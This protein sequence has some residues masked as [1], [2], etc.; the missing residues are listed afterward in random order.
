MF[1]NG[2]PYTDF[3]EMNLDWIIDSFNEF[4]SSFNELKQEWHTY[5]ELYAQ[6]SEYVK[7][8]FDNL[9]LQEE[10]NKIITE[11]Y[12][13]GRLLEIFNRAPLELS[14]NM[15]ANYW[16]NARLGGGQGCCYIGDNR[17]VFYI[18]DNNSN[19]GTLHCI[20]LNTYLELWQYQLPLYHA[21]SITYDRENGKLYAAACFD[22]SDW[23]TLVP[24]VL[25]V[26]ISN[27]ST[28]EEI[29]T[30]PVDLYSICYDN[31]NHVFY[32]STRAA[33]TIYKISEDF[34]TYETISLNGALSKSNQGVQVAHGGVVYISYYDPAIIQGFDVNTGNM[35]YQHAV[36][37]VVN[38]YRFLKEFEG[39]TYDYDNARY[40]GGF[41]TLG[42]CNKTYAGVYSFVELGLYKPVVEQMYS[43]P[44]VFNSS[45]KFIYVTA[46]LNNIKPSYMTAGEQLGS[47]YDAFTLAKSLNIGDCI[48]CLTG[49]FS[50]VTI[51]GFNGQLR[52]NNYANKPKINGLLN[53]TGDVFLSGIIL[54]GYYTTGDNEHGSIITRFCGKTKVQS[55]DFVLNDYASIISTICGEVKFMNGNTF[56][57]SGSGVKFK[58]AGEGYLYIDSF[59]NQSY[60]Q[61]YPAT[62][63]SLTTPYI[64][65]YNVKV[66]DSYVE[67]DG[68]EYTLE[69]PI[70][71]KRNPYMI[72]NDTIVP[73]NINI[74]SNVSNTAFCINSTASVVLTG[75]VSIN[76]ATNKLKLTRLSSY[77]LSTG[78]Y[79]A[80]VSRVAISVFI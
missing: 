67:N 44:Y 79:T 14:Q 43:S 33:G 22:Y 34:S 37:Q 42:N 17:I 4:L 9:D 63:F 45:R 69:L 72:V 50:N 71:L 53:E 52:A 36:K 46:D 32:G 16:Y 64:L 74:Y 47:L 76:L 35:V 21:N 24:Y 29:I 48:I 54:N 20:D 55:C 60:G 65:D 39:L 49:E 61:G 26:D 57:G 75:A 1:V 78:T 77:D 80:S 25:K 19:T 18:T 23:D 68:T 38:Q 5:E 51:E 30:A 66:H 10:V 27:P 59:Y 8:Y 28:V 13:D 2:Y 15:I 3:H 70:Q 58:V 31:E 40:I 41:A 12:N 6:L 73:L 56:S 11:M 62:D 7:T